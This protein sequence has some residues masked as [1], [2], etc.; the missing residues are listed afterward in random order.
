MRLRT[1]RLMVGWVTML[2]LQVGH[3]AR[4]DVQPGD[5][6]TKANVDQVTSLISPGVQWCVNHGMAIKVVPYKHIEWDK[7]YRDATEKY[8]G[9]VKLSADGRTISGH[10]AGLPFPNLDPNDP[11]I[12]IKI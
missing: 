11:Q 12:A 4:A 10:V 3:H 2:A 6:I 9:Q 7:A 5:V 1:R 8:S